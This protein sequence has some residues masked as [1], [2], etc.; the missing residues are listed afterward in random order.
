M[1]STATER[2]MN[3]E[4]FSISLKNLSMRHEIAMFRAIAIWLDG[5]LTKDIIIGTEEKQAEKRAGAAVYKYSF[6]WIHLKQF[7]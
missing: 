1:Q 5:T 3:W 7:K 2:L 6:E 4:S